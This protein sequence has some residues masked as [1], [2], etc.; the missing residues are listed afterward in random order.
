MTIKEDAQEMKSIKVAM[1]Q[2]VALDGDRAGNFIRIENALQEAKQNGAEL[3]C[4]PETCIYGWV[5]SGAHQR[6]H[7]IPGADSDR[8]CELARKYQLHL[9]I[10][11]AEKDGPNLHDS[12]VLI[13]DR[14]N[15]LI[16]HRK[17]NIL[18]S[19]MTPPYTPGTEVQIAQT[20][21]GK[22][23]LLICADT[24][25][26]ALL[27]K[28]AALKPDLVIVPYGWAAP[29]E[30][31]PQHGESLVETVTRAAIAIGA[32]VIGTDLVGEITKGPWTGQIFGGQ[33]VA[34]DGN[35]LP[36]AKG[37]DRDRDI[38][39]FILDL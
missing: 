23:G 33:S 38:I 13:D 1:C 26:S 20:N 35:G 24:F 3:A 12:A 15:I 30:M 31:W 5:N 9:A 11:L 16:K 2:I 34:A 4:F 22:I 18:T 21:F 8:L 27:E 19:L 36:L 29:E 32:P 7:P 6:A 17:I 39:I 25:K 14:G 37:E 28:M 10:G